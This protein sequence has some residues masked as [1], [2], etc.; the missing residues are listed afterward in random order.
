MSYRLLL[1]AAVLLAGCT[2]GTTPAMNDRL[3]TVMHDYA[4]DG[5][6][7]SVLVVRDGKS[8]ERRSYG[9]ADLEAK[10]AITPHT[11]FRLASVSKQFNA[12]AILLLAQDGKLSIDDPIKRFLPTLPKED[13]AITIRHLLTH[14]SGLID[15]EDL[16]DPKDTS[17]IHDRGVLRL[18]EQERKHYFTP[19]TAYRYSN[20]GYALLALIVERASGQRYADFLRT[21]IFDKLGMRDTVAYENGISTVAHR[22]YG[23]TFENGA[24]TRTDQST[25][26][27]VLGDGGIYSSI[28]DLAK[29]DAALYDDRLLPQPVWKQA[30][31]PATKTDDPTIEYGFG[32]RITG[33]TLWHSG[34]TVGFR[35]VIV[36]YPKRRL[37][38]VVLTNR[39]DPEPYETAKKIAA[40]YLD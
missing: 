34:E 13:D 29:W 10:T 6:G 8:I 27:A 26:S 7:A 1:G 32:W 23:Y 4:G 24:W 19:G 20:S 2:A 17:Q 33:E 28:D 5:P 3:D 22:A 40:L 15:Y 39:N 36:R 37:T 25:T 12:A 18:L 9:F 31:T 11:N 35:N 14:T 38:V 16:M 30:F 21:R